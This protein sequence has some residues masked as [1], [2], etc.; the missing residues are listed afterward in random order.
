MVIFFQLYIILIIYDSNKV[1]TESGKGRFIVIQTENKTIINKI[2][3]R[4]NSVFQVFT[5]VNSLLPTPVL[6][7]KKNKK[8]GKFHLKS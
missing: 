2:T 6:V 5:T 1:Q 7:T 8:P 3:T 4:I